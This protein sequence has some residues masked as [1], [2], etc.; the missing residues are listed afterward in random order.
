MVVHGMRKHLTTIVCGIIIAVLAAGAYYRNEIWGSEISL[1]RN[2]ASK[3]PNKARPVINLSTALAQQGRFE[4]AKHEIRRFLETHPASIEAYNN[5]GAI[6]SLQGKY[7]EALYQVFEAL[8][9][10]PKNAIAHNNVGAIL[11]K[12]GKYD[13]ALIHFQEAMKSKP[14]FED[15]R[16]NFDM[17]SKALKKKP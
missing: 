10:D 4:E 7:D 6:L 1:W 12:Q 17:L 8:H 16:K 13:E 15:A 2:A 3:S 9:I 11:T 5:L 14:D